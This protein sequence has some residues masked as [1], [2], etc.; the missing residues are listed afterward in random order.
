MC[1]TWATGFKPTSEK[2]TKKVC[3]WWRNQNE[4]K[5]R[6]LQAMRSDNR[7]VVTK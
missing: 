3:F 4:E 1:L 2:S 5:L 7:G 6:R